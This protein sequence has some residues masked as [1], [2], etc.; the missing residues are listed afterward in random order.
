MCT[1][2]PARAT[3]FLP[4]VET[5]TQVTRPFSINRHICISLLRL[6]LPILLWGSN[7]LAPFVGVDLA[8][9]ASSDIVGQIL[10]VTL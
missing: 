6:H 1:T 7:H 3:I 10:T 4:S 2:A 5:F 8:K 9:S